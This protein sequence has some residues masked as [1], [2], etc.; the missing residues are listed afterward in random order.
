MSETP[1]SPPTN[2]ALLYFQAPA[3]Y[4][5]RWA[6][7]GQIVE[8]QNG[9]TIS[10]RD[11]LQVVIATLAAQNLPPL[12]A[13][14]LLLAACS[15]G[16]PASGGQGVLAGLATMFRG[17][18]GT[19]ELQ[20]YL[21]QAC[22]FMDLVHE[23]PPELRTGPRKLQ[24]FQEVLQPASTR[25]TAKGQQLVAER[26][27]DFGDSQGALAQWASGRLDEALRH[28]G[29]AVAV[30]CFLADLQCLDQ[31]FQ[32]FPSA[33]L[34]AL[35]LRTGLDQVPKPLPEPALPEEPAAQP[36]DLLDQLAQ[37]P[38]TAGLAR[39]TQRLVA[40]LRIPMHTH[41]ASEQPLGG[42]ADVA[43]R[44]NFDRLLLS[45]LA[46]D[47][48]TLMARLVN[49]EALYLRREAPPAP[50]VRPRAVL[51]DTTLRMWGVPR[52]FAL[53]AALAWTR[54][55]QHGRQPTPVLAYA[56]GGRLVEWADLD[57]FEGV[58]EALGR[59]DAALHPGAALQVFSRNQ[60]DYAGADALLIT[61]AEQLTEPA[62]AAALA[63]ATATLRF[64]LTVN[65]SGE[66]QLYE[67]YNGYRSLLSTT[68]FNLEELLFAPV[69]R[70]PRRIPPPERWGRPL[71]RNSRPHC[72]FRPPACAFR[73]A[74]PFITASACWP[75]PT[76]TGCCSGPTGVPEP[77]SCCLALSQVPFISA[78]TS[79]RTCS[80]WSRPTSCCASTGLLST[81]QVETWNLLIW[82]TS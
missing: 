25:R 24:L 23:L 36:T 8:W 31:A 71:C 46:H 20:F 67:F 82:T 60:T 70:Q 56:L 34:L 43:N 77:G 72:F 12:G 19:D 30:E 65:R 14:L 53:A 17:H 62:F 11:E 50:E 51:L 10:Y 47:D 5:W 16:W 68:S 18:K 2:T 1:T 63:E 33:D 73:S 59:L 21:N 81:S 7:S 69:P 32:R 38:R 55:S 57:S 42:I 75:S 40:A 26:T 3:N 80:C 66:L 4:F 44:G 13:V 28:S 39:L 64:L 48:L 37:D 78:P 29:P 54:N 79:T 22:R 27:L 58:V 9:V 6:D 15:Q 52:V 35:R 76:Q 61:A 49:N 41:H 74:I 45:E